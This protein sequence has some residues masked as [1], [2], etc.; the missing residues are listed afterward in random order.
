MARILLTA[1]LLT[2]VA[3]ASDTD[4]P[5]FLG[6]HR[7][8]TSS[9][10]IASTWPAA[11]PTVVWK[12]EI[13]HGFSG[14]VVGGDKLVLFHRLANDETVD[15]YDVKTHQRLWRLQYPTHYED[16]FGFDDGPRAT[17]VISEGRVYTFGAEGMLSCWSL[18]PGK[19]LWQ[20][21]TKAKFNAGKGFF[22]MACS[23]LVEGNAVI[24]NVGGDHAGIVA[25]DRNTGGVLWKATD[26]EAGYASPVAATFGGK[27]YL[28]DFNR[29]GLVALD[30]V[31]GNQVLRFPFRSRMNASVN[32]ATPLVIGDLIFLSASYQTGAALLRFHENAPDTIWSADNVLSSHYATSVYHDGFLYGFDGRQEF[33]PSLRCV[34][35]KTGKVRWSQD[36]FGAGTVM[37]ANDRLL[38]LTEKGELISA[39]ATPDG[40]KPTARAQILPFECRAYP[41]LADSLLY[42][43]SKETLVCVELRQRG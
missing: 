21:D 11:G 17:P 32:A 14:P 22:G 20:V 4:W 26:D 8:G 41:A 40:F 23:P 43:R 1:L 15:C 27:R 7:D 29:A 10:A 13:G 6:P 9:C 2:S 34:E 16:D 35:L 3:R 24:V 39:P 37:L 25:F 28:L 33:G 5:Q 36:H 19:R 18:Q 30:P 38:V 31:N 12:T 42:A